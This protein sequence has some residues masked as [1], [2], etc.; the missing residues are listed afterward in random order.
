ML[1][2][3]FSLFDEVATALLEYLLQVPESASFDALINGSDI[4]LHVPALSDLEIVSALRRLVRSEGTSIPR[5]EQAIRHY[6]DLPLT[7][8]GHEALLHRC[9][10]LR[11]VLSAYDAAYVALAEALEA[12]LVTADRRLARAAEALGITCLSD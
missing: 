3:T 9:F 7:R 1:D 8:H 6:L 5:A 2:I 11:D 10:E 4:D 12:D